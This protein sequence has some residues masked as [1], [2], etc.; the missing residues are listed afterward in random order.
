MFWFFC[1]DS[2]IALIYHACSSSHPDHQQLDL[3]LSTLSALHTH[4]HTHLTWLSARQL[5]AAYGF[6][7]GLLHLVTHTWQLRNM[8]GPAG[9][10]RNSEVTS[11]IS[12]HVRSLASGLGG[13][14]KE[15]AWDRRRDRRAWCGPMGCKREGRSGQQAKRAAI[16]F[17]W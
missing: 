9:Q 16:T 6:R 1:R 7:S 2:L 12:C 11:A 3:E 15:S 13:V 10:R 4:L 8:A 5:Y 17:A 14:S